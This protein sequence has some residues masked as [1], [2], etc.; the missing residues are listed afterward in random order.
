[1]DESILNFDIKYYFWVYCLSINLTNPRPI[2][3]NFI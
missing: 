1:M 3:L 2:K